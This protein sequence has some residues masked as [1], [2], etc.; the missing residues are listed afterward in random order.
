MQHIFLAVLLQSLTKYPSKCQICVDGSWDLVKN[1][2]FLIILISNLDSHYKMFLPYTYKFVS[3]YN[4][5]KLC[6]RVVWGI[7]FE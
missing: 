1:S 2:F 3:Y 4:T 6:F 7:I 5:T